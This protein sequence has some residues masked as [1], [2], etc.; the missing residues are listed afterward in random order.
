MRLV[1]ARPAL[2]AAIRRAMPN[3]SRRGVSHASQQ[4][5]SRLTRTGKSCGTSNTNRIDYDLRINGELATGHVNFAV[6]VLKNGWVSVPVP[7]G[8]P[9]REARLDSKLVS[10]VPSFTG[11]G[12]HQLNAVFSHPGRSVLVLEIALPVTSAA[13]NESI[14]LPS[15]DSGVSRAAVELPRRGFDIQV[16][17]GL[18]SEKS[19]TASNN[20]FTRRFSL[21]CWSASCDSRTHGECSALH[22]ASRVD[23]QC[24][25][26]PLP[27][28]DEQSLLPLLVRRHLK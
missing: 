22:P 20:A 15:A 28:F 27:R 18:L 4:S 25:G 23:G 16:A 5:L 1:R 7:T 14:T 12:G 3:N 21:P 13:G 19:E 9:V 2:D 8:L 26:S 10:L 17:S 24:R 6:D 11:K